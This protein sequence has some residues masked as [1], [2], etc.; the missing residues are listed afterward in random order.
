M[1]IWSLPSKE[2]LKNIHDFIANDSEYYAKQVTSNIISSTDN[3]EL[4]PKLGRVVPEFQNENIREIFQYSYR[5]IYELKD[6][7]IYILNII[8]GKRKLEKEML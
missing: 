4:F 8:H 1:V 3:L 2:S 7:K 5:I 6:E